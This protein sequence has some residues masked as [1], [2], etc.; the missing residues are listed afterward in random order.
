MDGA[1]DEAT[2]PAWPAGRQAVLVVVVAAA[3][4][5]TIALADAISSTTTEGVPL[6]AAAG[7]TLAALLLV[8]RRVWPAVLVA[9]FATNAA[10]N[11]AID[12]VPAT[13]FLS[14]LANTVEPLL[15][16]HLVLRLLGGP[17]NLDVRRDLLVFLGGAVVAGPALGAVVGA[18]S[19]Q[20]SPDHPDHLDVLG[21]WFT[22]DAL[23]VLVVGTLVVA[24]V[25]PATS[26]RAATHPWFEAAAAAAG[27]IG[28]TVLAFWGSSP[29]LAYVVLPPLAWAATRFGVRGAAAGGVAV[30]AIADW[31]TITDHGLF[32]LLGSEQGNEALWQLQLFLAVVLTTAFVLGAHVSELSEVE[33]ALL[34]S[35]EQQRFSSMLEASPDPIL[36]VRASGTIAHL[37]EQLL[38]LSG[39]SREELLGRPWLEL[40]PAAHRSQVRSVF[41]EVLGQ[42]AGSR[43]TFEMDGLGEQRDRDLEVAVSPLDTREGRVL[44]ATIRDVSD[45]KAAE[46][47]KTR[48]LATMSHEIRTPM[49]AVTSLIDLL[50]HTE[51]DADQRSLLQT[52]RRSSD[53][54]LRIIDDTLDFSKIEAGML[55][56]EAVPINLADEV[57]AIASLMEPAAATKGIS[58]RCATEPP[59]PA[60]VVGDPV[61]IRQILLNLV[62][63]AIKFTTV[64]G[65]MLEAE[66]PRSEGGESVP[67]TFTVR[68]TG[69]GIEDDR[70]AELF[71]PYT[72]AEHSTTRLYG[73]T[74]LG[75]SIVSRLVDLHDGRIDVDSRPGA[76]STFV[77]TLPL[78]VAPAGA[79]SSPRQRSRTS[80][81]EID[82]GRL[83]G[84]VVLAAEDNT[85]NRDVL[86]RQLALLGCAC[87]V[88][89]D[90]QEALDRLGAGGISLVLT[91][92][93]MPV[94]DGFALTRAIRAHE[95]DQG[96]PRLPV[97]AITAT[98]TDAEGDRCTA[99]G[100]D[101]RLTKPVELGRL[102]TLLAD[103]LPS[104]PVRPATPLD[105]GVLR[106]IVGDDHAALVDVL[107][108]CA[109]SLREQSDA[110]EAG[111]RADDVAAMAGAAH[112][113]AG[114]AASVGATRL[115]ALARGVELGARTAPAA[116]TR[117]AVHWLSEEVDVVV[118]EARALEVSRG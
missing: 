22:G 76:G 74:G 57:R 88:V 78:E 62:G 84:H 92:C 10:Y 9:T 8:P 39:R 103:L 105:L 35:E 73:G 50:D 79:E 114:A 52:M 98:A 99:A 34:V 81:G 70:L 59:E 101:A 45:R 44:V 28:L 110:L 86:R 69:I 11:L 58:L 89:G 12:I 66:V 80:A 102:A 95:R 15:G 51:L 113:L 96:R 83:A 116:A 30:A 77:V 31:A 109:A 117:A 17:P 37:N 36:V 97:V 18:T 32:A 115:A 72:Q 6:W 90:G 104:E 65:V 108:S 56:L 107:A 67:V 29:V 94:L 21:R 27:V 42:A 112:R 14:A 3:H 100:M 33:S 64:G 24:W 48:F 40:L 2:G 16:A 82:H 5:G 41:D 23:G 60:T 4:I 46:E 87:E 20:F 49:S 75:L 118:A 61:R 47:A 85:V 19:T 54:L 25:R 53:S 55:E 93:H 13:S 106:S 1:R 68:D 26:P 43:T 38:A 111:M 71:R 63:N 91:D 7:V